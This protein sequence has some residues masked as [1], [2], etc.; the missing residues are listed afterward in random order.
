MNYNNDLVPPIHT[1]IVICYICGC[2]QTV[3][4]YDVDDVHINAM[5]EGWICPLE[6]PA[7]C[8]KC[9][10]EFYTRIVSESNKT[11]NK[12]DKNENNGLR[13]IIL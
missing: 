11:N 4:G 13:F 7:I 2:E 9:A 6:Y 5:K 12:E 1:M 10:G 3:T 8:P